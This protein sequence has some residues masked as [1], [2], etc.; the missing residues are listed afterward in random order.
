MKK[1]N[2][3]SIEVIEKLKE[4]ELTCFKRLPSHHYSSGHCEAQIFDNE[5]DDIFDIEIIWGIDRDDVNTELWSMDNET[6]EIT[7]FFEQ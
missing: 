2:V 5:D 3:D 7:E 6:L 1:F 4:F